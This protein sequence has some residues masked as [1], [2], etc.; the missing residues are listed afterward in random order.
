M[1]NPDIRNRDDTDPSQKW[2]TRLGLILFFIYLM[3]YLGFVLISAFTPEL[4]D[5]IVGAGLNLAVV[6]GF[7]L[8]VIA[9]VMSVIYGLMCRTE[10]SA[11]NGHQPNDQ[12]EVK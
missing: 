3:F 10:P 7:A 8:I 4:M 9:I 2:N 6:Y 5:Q 1:P 11:P 12:G